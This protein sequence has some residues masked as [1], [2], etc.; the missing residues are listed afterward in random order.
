MKVSL[1]KLV[2][3]IIIIIIIIIIINNNICDGY[4][5]QERR[6]I[7]KRNAKSDDR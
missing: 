3:N 1:I 6:I 5:G 7:S 4:T 2:F